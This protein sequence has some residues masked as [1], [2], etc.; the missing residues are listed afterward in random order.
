MSFHVLPVALNV[1]V[2]FRGF[3][4]QF[5]IDPADNILHR[6]VLEGLPLG[7]V[8]ANRTAKIILWSAGAEQ[9]TGYLRQDVLGR[10]CQEDFL[11]HSDSGNNV[12]EGSSIPLMAALRDGRGA[13]GRF[14][15]RTKGGHYFPA[16]VWAFPLRD[17]S[18]TML[19]A[20]EVFEAAV[21]SSISERRQSKLG[22][23]GCLDPLTGA[24][25]HSMI[26]GR[27]K[28]SL[29]LHAL[30]PVPFSVMCISM[31]D[32]PKLRE[33]YGQAAVEAALR[34]LAQTLE[35]C[36]RPTDLVGRLLDQEF[37]VILSECGENDVLKVGDRLCK[38]VR[39]SSIAWWGDTLHITVSIGATVVHDNDTIGSLVSRAEDALRE[40]SAGGGNRVALITS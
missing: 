36:L 7:V 39:R 24:L 29:S 26:Q 27:L 3:A 4:D 8:V 25:N 31:D 37:L 19:G 17:D 11:Q 22:A 23:Y 1:P 6:L 18:G 9:A 40:S 21:A 32:L 14:S 2:T 28:E 5:M 33:R 30:Y 20:V 38:T 16:K 12:V 10:S 34:T 35:G 15:L 13:T